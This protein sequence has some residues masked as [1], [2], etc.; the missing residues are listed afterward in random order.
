MRMLLIAAS[1][2]LAGC[3]TMPPA[4]Q[5]RI[6]PPPPVLLEVPRPLP[7]VPADLPRR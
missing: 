1:A 5:C 3:L 4:V 7:P 6:D 2:L